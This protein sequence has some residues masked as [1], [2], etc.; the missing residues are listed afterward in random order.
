MR[1]LRQ[2][3]Q[4]GGGYGRGGGGPQ[5]PRAAGGALLGGALLAGGALFLSNSLF[6]VDGGQRAIKYKRMS[7][8]SKEIYN[9][10]KCRIVISGLSAVLSWLFH[11][12]TNC[13][14]AYQHSL[15]RDADC[16]RCPREAP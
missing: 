4:S 2:M 15:V 12:L 10:G 11:L 13:R 16:V 14:N 6:N 5:M 1:R 8:V 3:Q 9:E 7:G